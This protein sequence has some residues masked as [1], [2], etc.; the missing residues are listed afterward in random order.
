MLVWILFMNTRRKL[1]LHAQ[2]LGTVLSC[3]AQADARGAT[4]VLDHGGQAV[5]RGSCLSHLLDRGARPLPA[6]PLAVR[7]TYLIEKNT[8]QMSR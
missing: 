4:Q 8:R 5:E 3:G 2:T 6:A 1:G 7:R